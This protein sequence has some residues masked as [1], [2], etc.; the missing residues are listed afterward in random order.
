MNKQ[1]AI[2]RVEEAV[3]IID[4][5]DFVT[6]MAYLDWQH[7]RLADLYKAVGALKTEARDILQE[8]TGDDY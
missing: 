6:K 1:Q 5:L 8:V 2:S 4:D 3:D 7:E